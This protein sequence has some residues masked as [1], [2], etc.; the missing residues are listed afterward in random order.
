M[1]EYEKVG[2]SVGALVTEKQAAY[3]DA[4]GKTGEVMRLL[5][6]DGIPH[7]KMDDALTVVRVLDK[8]FRIATARDAF[9]ESPWED[10]AGYALLAVVRVGKQKDGDV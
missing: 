2:A 6:P 10:I 9:G 4:F 1:S 5:Y 3:G 7:E 8:L